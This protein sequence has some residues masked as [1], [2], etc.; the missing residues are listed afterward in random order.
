MGRLLLLVVVTFRVEKL[1]GIRAD[2]DDDDGLRFIVMITGA[3]EMQ[4]C[5]IILKKRRWNLKKILLNNSHNLFAP[6]IHSH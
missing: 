6:P 2:D 3:D 5:G 1:I 4:N